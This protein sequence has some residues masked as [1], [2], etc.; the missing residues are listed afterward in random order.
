VEGFL[1]IICG[2][3][4]NYTENNRTWVTDA[5]YINV[6]E[7]ADI[8]NASQGP[9]GSYL[10]HLRLFPKPL[11]KSCYQLPVAPDVPHLLRLWFAV[12]NYSGFKQLPSFQLSIETLG[13]L[14]RINQTTQDADAHYTERIFVSSGTVLYICL[15]RTSETHDPFISAIELRTLQNGMYGE[16]K[17]GTLLWPGTYNVGGNSA[18]AFR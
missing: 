4:T 15:I 11:N 6:G 5:D 16:A 2:G 18:V 10:H 13:M 9:Y 1:S 17:P 12:G 3:K 8:G 7:T 14:A